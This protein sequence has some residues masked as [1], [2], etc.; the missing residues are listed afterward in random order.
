[1]KLERCRIASPTG[2]TLLLALGLATGCFRSHAGEPAT[3]IPP[4][5]MDTS[6]PEGKPQTAVFSGGCFWGVQGVYQHVR[7]VKNVLSGYA[8]GT[9][10][11]AHYE[12][13]SS[14]TTGHAESVQITFDPAEV[15]Y[16]KLLQIFFSVAHNPTQLNRQGPDYGT[17]YRSNIFYADEE[18]KKIADAYIQQLNSS[19]VFDRPIVTRV[20]PLPAF[21]PAEAYHQNFLLDNPRYPYIVVNDLPKIEHLKQL[22]PK[23]YTAEPV[24]GR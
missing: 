9:E 22:F 13:V 1:M 6:A 5:A 16:G 19:G 23:D 14:G 21:Y 20:D 17:Q 3:V 2:I 24:R 18:Q 10:P 11:D 7:G 12:I 4:P 15:S 8:G